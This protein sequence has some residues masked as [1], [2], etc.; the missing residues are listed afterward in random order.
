MRLRLERFD[1]AQIKPF[2]ISLLLGRRN[3]GKSTLLKDLMYHLREHSDVCLCFTPTESAAALFRTITPGALVHD[4]GLSL[5]VLEQLMAVQREI[6]RTP[7]KTMRRVTLVLDDC[8]ANA[9]ALRSPVIS[10]L[11]RNG[12][13]QKITVLLTSQY[14]TDLNPGLRA[15]VDYTFCMRDGCVQNKKR[16]HQFYAGSIGKFDDF[17][18]VF[19]TVTSNYGVFVVDNTAVDGT[20]ESTTFWY[21]ASLKIPGFRLTNPVYYKLE[22]TPRR[23]SGVQV[24]VT[25]PKLPTAQV[26]LGTPSTVMRNPITT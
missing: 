2:T 1:A 7:G 20:V 25:Q 15:Q 26:T 21:R 16:I 19:D 4:T 9:A 13:H 14:A 18:S 11:F 3:T 24:A 22:K 17:S 10:D 8:S 5:A 6:A 23:D 12:R